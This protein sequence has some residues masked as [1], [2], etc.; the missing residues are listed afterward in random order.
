MK[1]NVYG[2]ILFNA[3]NSLLKIMYKNEVHKKLETMLKTKL[4]N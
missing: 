3:I 2:R 1:I 4:F